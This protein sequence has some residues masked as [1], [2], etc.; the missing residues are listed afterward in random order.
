MCRCGKNRRSAWYI[1]LAALFGS[2]AALEY[3]AVK[4]ECHDPLSALLHDWK[5]GVPIALG[6]FILGVHCIKYQPSLAK[7]EPQ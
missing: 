5:L 2:L 3:P 4:H 7:G 1:W 6:G